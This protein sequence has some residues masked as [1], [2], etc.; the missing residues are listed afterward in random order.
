MSRFPDAGAAELLAICHRRCCVCHRFCGVKM[1][2]DHIV[3]HS[4]GGTDEIENAIAVCFECHAEI[5]SYNDQHP[6]GRKF[7]PEELRRHKQQWLE[8]IETRPEI[9]SSFRASESVGP[10]QALV[11]ELEFNVEVASERKVGD[12][13]C[14]FLTAQFHRSLE[15]GAISILDLSLKRQLHEAYRAMLKANNLAAQAAL[16]NPVADATH[17]ASKLLA[18]ADPIIKA[19][20]RSLLQFVGHDE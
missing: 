18:E 5:H 9:L 10:L 12:A 7:R 15:C 6:R 3:P 19:A 1:E 20:L 4:E 16:A 17:R 2:L 11:D 8:L 14:P 13:G